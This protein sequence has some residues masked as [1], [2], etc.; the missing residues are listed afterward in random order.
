ML[1]VMEPSEALSQLTAYPPMKLL[2]VAS[3]VKSPGSPTFHELAC[4][5]LLASVTVSTYT[6]ACR[7]VRS[8][9]CAVNPSGPLQE[10]DNGAVP[11]VTVASMAPLLAP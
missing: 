5:Q 1:M 4:W 2:N 7:P 3:T 10:T 8:S 6:P 11:P 9:I